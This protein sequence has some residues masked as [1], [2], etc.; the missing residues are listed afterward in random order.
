MTTKLAQKQ[1]LTLLN[2]KN[3]TEAFEMGSDLWSDCVLVG[4]LNKYIPK[5]YLKA[6]MEGW[7]E[8]EQQYLL[9]FQDQ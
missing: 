8:I 4:Q 2:P 5:K 7:Q 3:N 6:A 9:E 1:T